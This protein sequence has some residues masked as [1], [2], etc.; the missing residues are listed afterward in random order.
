MDK[1]NIYNMNKLFNGDH[2]SKISLL[3]GVISDPWYT[4]DFDTTYNQIL[5]GC[6][7]L[8]ERLR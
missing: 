5:K 2:D 6:N 1:E 7:D 8:L 3:N 4:R